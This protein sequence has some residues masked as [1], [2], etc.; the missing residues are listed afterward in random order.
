ME[1][2]GNVKVLIADDSNSDRLLLKTM[3]RRQ[4]Y[5]VVDAADGIEAVEL[6]RREQPDL[7]FIDALMHQG[8]GWR[9]I[10]PGYLSHL[11]AGCRRAGALPGS[12]R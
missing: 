8:R 10:H 2:K 7:V 1:N 12:G 6:Y 4:G 5:E 11:V 9:R 3:L